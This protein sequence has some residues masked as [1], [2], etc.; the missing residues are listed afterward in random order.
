MLYLTTPLWVTELVPP[1]GR[2]ILVGIVGLGGVLGYILAAYVGVGFFYYNSTK[3]AQWRGP[4]AI[5]CF[6]PLMLLAI[7]FWLPE[8]PRY[9]LKSN[10]TEKAWD[11]VQSLHATPSDPLHEY[12][13]AEFFQMRKQHELD[14]SLDGS[15]LAILKRRSY[16]K[17]AMISFFL[18][19][20]L[21]STGNLVVTSK[22]TEVFSPAFLL[23]HPTA[24]AASIFSEL[25]YDAG[26]SLQLLA[27]LYVGAIVAN[28]ISLTYVDRV[29]RNTML[30]AGVLLVT[31]ILAIETALQSQYL[32]TGNNAGLSAAAAFLFLFLAGFN[33]FLE[34]ISWY[35]ASEIF[36][37]HLRAKGMTIGVIGF[38]LVDILWLEIAPT[39]FAT[40]GWKYYLV[41]IC[42]SV[43]SAAIIFFTFPN[44]LRLPLEEVAKLFGDED[45]VAVYQKDIHI[46]H[47]KHQVLEEVE[48]V[49]FPASPLE[50]GSREQA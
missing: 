28:L 11:I 6:F 45:L 7:I 24:Y 42:I 32:G 17:R 23:I 31:V 26:G 41:F 29:P 38:C 48:E 39:A 20:M 44:T 34:A 30:G 4:L 22:L 25:G 46:D 37:T 27:G 50:E 13:R 5:G 40:I 15:W 21:Y 10:Q 47:E 9:L 1:R 14:A 2:S 8:S 3:S 36:P 12:A 33:C 35:Y 16:L 43:F 19:V 18:P 49:T